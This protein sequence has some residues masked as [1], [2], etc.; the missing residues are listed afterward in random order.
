MPEHGEYMSLGVQTIKRLAD[1]D[2][3]LKY[4]HRHTTS[5]GLYHDFAD[6]DEQASCLAALCRTFR[7]ESL[8]LV[9]DSPSQD[10]AAKG[11]DG[12]GQIICASSSDL[13]EKLERLLRGEAPDSSSSES[14]PE[15]YMYQDY[16]SD[17]D[18]DMEDDQH[19]QEDENPDD[20]EDPDEYEDPYQYQDE[21]EED[22]N[23]N[24]AD[25]LNHF[26]SHRYR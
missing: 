20:Y 18:E 16:M 5:A 1:D 15:G 11:L 13:V 12:V 6:I 19:D 14:D 21:S 3:P 4:R 25:R 17:Q 24:E 23:D 7:H 2:M 22:D 26:W 9:L 10:H 8:F